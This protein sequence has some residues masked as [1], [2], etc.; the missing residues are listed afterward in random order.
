MPTIYPLLQNGQRSSTFPRNIA[1]MRGQ[2]KHWLYHLVGPIVIHTRPLFYPITLT[3]ATLSPDSHRPSQPNLL[4]Y[5]PS[6]TPCPPTSLP[7]DP[8]SACSYSLYLRKSPR[9]NTSPKHF[10]VGEE[11]GNIYSTPEEQLLLSP[12]LQG[13]LTTRG[14]PVTLRL[15]VPPLPISFYRVCPQDITPHMLGGQEWGS[16][17]PRAQP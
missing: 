6:C 13:P 4:Y 1:D 8:Q 10:F 7:Q 15:S 17:L 16:S 12:P 9:S 14:S 11:A 3:P 2:G 5:L